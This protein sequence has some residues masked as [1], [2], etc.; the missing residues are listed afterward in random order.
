M[1]V[2]PGAHRSG[3]WGGGHEFAGHGPFL[4]SPDAR[5]LDFRASFADPFGSLMVRTFR[6]RGAIP[7]FVVADLSASMGFQGIGSKAE[8]LADFAG[9]VAYSAYRTGDTFGFVGCDETVRRELM[10]PLGF[11]KAAGLELKDKLSQ[12]TSAGRSADGLSQAAAYLGRQRA[13]VFLVSDFHF[14]LDCLDRLLCGYARHDLV[15]VVL[16]DSAEYEPKSGWGLIDLE[17]SE[18]GKRR[19]LLM[20]PRLREK[21]RDRFRARRQ[22]LTQVFAVRGREPFFLVDR[23]EPDALTRYFLQG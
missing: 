17:D 20:R 9:A 5:H 19:K 14:P 22:L 3:H 2:R 8:I 6:Q 18:S 15:P 13:L 7:V 4:S 12:F 1:G 23:F 11:H 10:L 16:W 21:L